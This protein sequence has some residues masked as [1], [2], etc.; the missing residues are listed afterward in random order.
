MLKAGDVVFA[1]S[2][3]IIGRGIRLAERLRWKHGAHWNHACILWHKD[4]NDEWWVIQADI[5]GVNH[6]KLTSVGEFY[7]YGLPEGVDAERVIK[8]HEEQLGSKYSV[9]SIASI[10]IDLLTPN[11]FPEFR[12]DHTWICS[13][14]VA[15]GLRAGGWFTPQSNWGSIYTVTPSQ[16]FDVL[17]TTNT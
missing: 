10:L 6:A 15:E 17:D 5:R 14:L 3:G 1:H 11:F 7:V 12:R 4:T 13:S 9:L 2:N 16:L 8:F